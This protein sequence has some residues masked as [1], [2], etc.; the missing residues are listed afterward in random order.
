MKLIKKPWWLPAAIILI[1]LLPASA[2]AASTSFNPTAD[3]EDLSDVLSLVS[4]SIEDGDSGVPINPTI[5]L[6]FSKNVVNVAVQK[7]NIGCF[8]LI[9]END[10]GIRIDIIMPDDQLQR[11]CKREIFIVPQKE[12]QPNSEYA[13]YIDNNL[14]SKNNTQID[15]LHIIRF[16]TGSSST[17]AVN[18]ILAGLG[19]NTVT[20]SSSLGKTQFS[21]PLATVLPTGE[22]SKITDI[23]AEPQRLSL[24]LGIIAAIMALALSAITVLKHKQGE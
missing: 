2:L 22:E 24:I 21:V 12:L 11:S 4:C 1:M 23:F 9:D 15:N 20:F 6:S 10:K 5:A 14:L 7:N 3:E 8:H 19:D 17:E 13:L 18:P 16:T